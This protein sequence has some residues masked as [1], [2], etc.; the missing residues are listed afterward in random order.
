MFFVPD[1]FIDGLV[2]EDLHILDVTTEAVGIGN[3]RGAVE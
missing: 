1:S 2:G 3:L